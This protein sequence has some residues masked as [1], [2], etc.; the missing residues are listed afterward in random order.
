[1]QADFSGFSYYS[2][3]AA[4]ARGLPVS[5][6]SGGSS[7]AADRVLR[8]PLHALERL[9]LVVHLHSIVEHKTE[10]CRLTHVPLFQTLVE[11]F[12]ILEHACNTHNESAQQSVQQKSRSRPAGR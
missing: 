4:Q 9:R 2:G 5:V 7:A 1:M 8:L 10:V 12:G 3:L 11:R 6:S